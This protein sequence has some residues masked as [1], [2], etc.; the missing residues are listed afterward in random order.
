MREASE[1]PQ[2]GKAG[3]STR[4]VSPAA[5]NLTPKNIAKIPRSKLAVGWRGGRCSYLEPELTG[6]ESNINL[7]EAAFIS[8]LLF[9]Q[10]FYHKDLRPETIVF[11]T[12]TPSLSPSE[13]SSTVTNLPPS[14]RSAGAPAACLKM[15]AKR[16]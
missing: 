14:R 2:H 3:R 7:T 13:T 16:A 15:Y 10:V 4:A 1:S 12:I 5:P 6:R 11:A 8:S 9:L